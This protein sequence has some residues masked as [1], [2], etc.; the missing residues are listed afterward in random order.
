[1]RLI[2]VTSLSEKYTRYPLQIKLKYASRENF[3]G[4]PISGYKTAEVGLMTPHAAE[5]LCQVQER[6]IKLYQYGLIIYDAYRPKRAVEDIF[7]WSI[8]PPANDYE[9]E[10]KAKH[11]PNI[12]KN[13]LF[14]CGYL[15]H[16]SGHCYGNT[17]DV[18]LVD[19]RHNNK[20]EM[21]ACYDYMDERSH[22]TITSK[23]IG[24][25]AYRN[26]QILSETMQMMGFEPYEREFWHFSYQG[27]K[28]REVLIPMDIEIT[29]ALK[30]IV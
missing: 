4:R 2:D 7:A 21:G 9:L 17:V 15:A 5:K 22:T 30:G 19:L 6:L 3:V 29:S 10:R 24:E 1:M 26:R 20:I 27:K 23:V 14:N 13:Q 28:G 12:E 25:E 8:Q 11:Y 18:F 16:D